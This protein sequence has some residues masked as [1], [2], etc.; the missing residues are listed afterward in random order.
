MLYVRFGTDKYAVKDC[1]QYFIQQYKDVWIDDPFVKNMSVVF[2]AAADV[3]EETPQKKYLNRMRP[4][5]FSEVF[6]L[7]MLM[8]FRPENEYCVDFILNPVEAEWLGKMAK[9]KDIKIAV[10]EGFE[11]SKYTDF[12][13]TILNTGGVVYDQKDCIVIG[14]RMVN[15]E[16][17][18]QWL[19]GTP[20]ATIVSR[21]SEE[22]M[23][24]ELPK[25][26]QMVV[27]GDT[28]ETEQALEII[29]RTDDVFVLDRGT[30]EIHE[31]LGPFN[32]QFHKRWGT[33]LDLQDVRNDWIC[34]PYIRGAH[35]WCRPSGEIGFFTNVG[36]WPTVQETFDDWTKILSAFPFLRINVTLMDRE[37][38][39]R[40][41][42]LW[43]A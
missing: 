30:E 34:S 5:D 10:L 32:A 4:E 24:L 37:Y 2:N 15:Y 8:Y 20:D 28:I 26:S 21:S 14:N 33:I 31:L 43:S 6:R 39:E 40:G 11:L 29:R 41:V 7:W 36:K 17:G 1:R 23:E 12:P 42:T 19:L 27:T 35:G 25:W 13:V 3:D 9:I 22:L 18:K 16:L 38:C